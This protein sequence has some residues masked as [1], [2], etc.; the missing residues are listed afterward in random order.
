[1]FGNYLKI[2]FRNILRHKEYSFINITGLVIGMACSILILLWVVDELSFDGF[3][4]N[5]DN[6]YRI[7]RESVYPDRTLIDPNT[8]APLAGTLKDEFPEIVDVARYV[9]RGTT[10][11]RYK[12]QTFYETGLAITDPGFFR[13]FSYPFIQGDKNTALN[14]KYS[15]VLTQEIAEKYF[16]KENPIGKAVNVDNKQDYIVTGVI[17]NVPPNSHLKFKMVIPLNLSGHFWSGRTMDW[18]NNSFKTYVLLDS[19]VSVKNFGSKI[20]DVIQM[21]VPG[22]PGKLFLVPLS[23]IHLHSTIG[24][25]GEIGAIKYVYIFSLIALFVLS[26]ACI[27][28]VNLSTAKSV[29]RTKE[30]GVR[31]VIGARKEDIVIQFYWETFVMIVIAFLLAVILVEFLLPFYNTLTGKEL[32]MNILNNWKIFIGLSGILMFTCIAAGSYPAFFLSAFRPVKV[33][34]GGFKSGAKGAFY[35]K[36]LVVVQF[37]LSIAMIIGTVTVDKQLEYIQEKELGWERSGLIYIPLR[38][39]SSNYYQALR[40]EA[41]RD[42]GV[43]GISASDFLPVSYGSSTWGVDWDGKDAERQYS[44]NYNLVDFDFIETLKIE[45]VEGRSFS[46]DYSTDESSSY[47]VNEEVV[48]LMGLKS[49]VGANFSLWD[50]KGKIIGVVKNFHFQPFHEEIKPLVLAVQKSFSVM[51]VRVDP[52]QISSVVESLKT[53][54]ENVVPGIP[55]SYGIVNDVFNRMYRSEEKMSD[56]LTYFSILAILV[57]CMGLYGLVSF[58]VSQKTKEIGIRKTLGATVQD[59][60]TVLSRDIILLVVVANIA[61]WPIAFMAMNKWLQ[62]FAYRTSIGIW[63]FVLAGSAVFLIASLT[64]AY[65]TVKATFINPVKALKYE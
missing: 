18:E 24:K 10:I 34:K 25:K 14:D 42:T 54:W 36:L 28:F 22:V 44:F 62:G 45:M 23:D 52:N 5:V 30:I 47:I 19:R 26:I 60:I 15:I 63:T 65:Q 7:E 11:L 21:H 35:R 12:G 3:N 51:L 33:L 41:K 4:A 37:V 20:V 2:A 61:A 40:T 58:T 39:D 32:S 17:K 31:K 16:G 38:G 57:A 46:R 29:T 1:M 6:L 59:I 49:A 48:K 50:K 56:V 53:T 27:N 13:V 64:I 8:P 9:R 55:F 43:L